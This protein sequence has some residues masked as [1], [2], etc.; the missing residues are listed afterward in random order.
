MSE[1]MRERAHSEIAVDKI[2]FVSR[3][4]WMRYEQRVSVVSIDAVQQ[5][6]C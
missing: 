6:P 5:R 4:V 3:N 1:R 2:E